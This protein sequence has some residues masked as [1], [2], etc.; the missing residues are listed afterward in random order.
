MSDTAESQA[1]AQVASIVAMVA[2]LN[3]DYDRLEELRDKKTEG[4][5]V[6][7][8]NMPGYMPDAEPCA[9]DTD[10]EARE[11]VAD[12]MA[13]HEGESGDFGNERNIEVS[14]VA[15][16]A[17]R[18][19]AG[20]YGATFGDCHYWVTFQPNALADSG[21]AEELAELEEAAGDCASE[22]EARGAIEGDALSIEV[23][24]GWA[25]SKDEFEAE[26]FR[27]V[28]CTGGPHVELVGD[29]YRGTPSR[30]R[31]LYRDWGTS[32]E[33]FPESEEREALETYCSQFYFGE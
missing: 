18:S 13:R 9:F 7:G 27:I 14:P 3:V 10:S 1:R 19:G 29:L 30:I 17:C 11:Y 5:Y 32:G 24:S 8:W 25:S 21:E 12:E 15:I 4:H 22:E 26:E 23:R 2:A 20:E 28:L 6:A 16:D 31:V 33:Y